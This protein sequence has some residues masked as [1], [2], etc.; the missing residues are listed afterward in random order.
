[1][2][3]LHFPP[4]TIPG[5]SPVSYTHPNALQKICEE[6]ERTVWPSD[7][8]FFDDYPR[9]KF[10]IRRATEAEIAEDELTSG[11]ASF[12]P[13]GMALVLIKHV[14]PGVRMRQLFSTTYSD[15]A[16]V[17]RN[18]PLPAGFE[19]PEDVCRAMYRRIAS[20]QTRKLERQVASVVKRASKKRRCT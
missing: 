19:P 6:I 10:R 18:L 4:L 14:A 17:V 15:D 5:A 9:R 16:G 11:R 7:R 8:K 20:S 12:F 1:L 13:P 2:A 3:A